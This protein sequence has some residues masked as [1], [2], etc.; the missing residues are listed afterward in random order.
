MTEPLTQPFPDVRSVNADPRRSVISTLTLAGEGTKSVDR[1]RRTRIAYPA[2]MALGGTTL[3]GKI[4]DV[5]VM[6]AGGLPIDLYY[7]T[8]FALDETEV[9]EMRGTMSDFVGA[10]VESPITAAADKRFAKLAAAARTLEFN[11]LLATT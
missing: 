2:K 1:D 7:L 3:T 10:F 5:Q 9:R 8:P 11:S 4:T 6:G